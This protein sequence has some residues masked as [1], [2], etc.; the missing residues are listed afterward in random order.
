MK[1]VCGLIGFSN[2]AYQ[3]SVTILLHNIRSANA[4][5]KAGQG[6]N[7][8]ARNVLLLTAFMKMRLE[9]A[10]SDSGLVTL[11]PLPLSLDAALIDP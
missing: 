6:G 11:V 8:L 5:C 4:C 10:A 3:L 9:R 1:S 7:L 2:K